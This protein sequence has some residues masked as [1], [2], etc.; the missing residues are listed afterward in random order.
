MVHFITSRLLYCCTPTALILCVYC[1]KE[2]VFEDLE[3]KQTVF[4]EVENL[5][6]ESVILS[7]STSC[8]MPSNVFSRVQNRTRCIISHPVSFDYRYIE[9]ES[10]LTVRLYY[11]IVRNYHVRKIEIMKM[12][13]KKTKTNSDSLVYSPHSLCV[14]FSPDFVCSSA[15][16]QL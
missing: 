8:L 4:H 1:E 6:T 13:I 16:F 12:F 9:N 5:V 10:N 3:A 2:C 15:T 14:Y 7:S 11:E